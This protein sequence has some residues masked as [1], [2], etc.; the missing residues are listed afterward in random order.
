[1]KKELC[2]KYGLIYVPVGYWYEK[3]INNQ[4]SLSKIII[5]IIIENTIQLR[6]I[7]KKELCDIRDYRSPN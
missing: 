3:I 4:N 2:E 1:M 5:N 6:N 7:M